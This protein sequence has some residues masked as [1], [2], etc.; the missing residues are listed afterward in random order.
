MIFVILLCD[1][2][3]KVSK[4]LFNDSKILKDLECKKVYLE[5]IL[6]HKSELNH[7]LKLQMVKSVCMKFYSSITSVSEFSKYVYGEFKAP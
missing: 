7:I 2:H 4:S 3:I 6:N 1:R 5:S